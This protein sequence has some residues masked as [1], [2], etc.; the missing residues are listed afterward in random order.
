MRVSIDLSSNQDQ[1][2]QCLY[3]LPVVEVSVSLSDLCAEVDEM[4]TEQKVVYG[5]D[6]HGVTH[7]GG[8]VTGESKS[9][10]SRD[11]VVEMCISSKLLCGEGS[12]RRD[13]ISGG[14]NY[15]SGS[16]CVSMTAARGIPKLDAGPQK[17]VQRVSCQSAD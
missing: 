10:G 1:R 7:E 5:S 4:A 9:H 16:F 12:S 14:L 17:S 8:R 11:T 15:I 13:R 3:V 2:E 6:G